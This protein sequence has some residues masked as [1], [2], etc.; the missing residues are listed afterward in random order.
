MKF[1][2]KEY[3]EKYERLLNL[4]EKENLLLRDEIRR[5]DEV[6]NI[7]LGNFSNCLPEHSNYITSK[8]TDAS[9]QT[10]HQT[11]NNTQ[12]STAGNNHRTLIASEKKAQEAQYQSVK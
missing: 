8:N 5:E 2:E 9:T 11:K 10:D 3:D 1:K 4:L 6:I 12:I 7:L